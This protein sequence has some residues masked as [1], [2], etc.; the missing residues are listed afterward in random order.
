MVF[1]YIYTYN[2]NIHPIPFRLIT[3]SH[4]NSEITALDNKQRVMISV[5]LLE[6]WPLLKMLNILATARDGTHASNN[7]GKVD[8][9]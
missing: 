1:L 7:T 2:F 8:A 9:H 4:F 5:P 6:N 3:R